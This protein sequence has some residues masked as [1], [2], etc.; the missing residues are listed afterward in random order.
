MENKTLTDMIVREVLKKLNN[1]DCLEKNPKSR[2]AALFCGG[3][4]GSR[5]ALLELKKIVMAGYDVQ[6]FLTPAAE[7]VLGSDLL[8]SE[9]G[10]I[11]MFTETSEKNGPE[12]IQNS[13]IILVPV[14]TI[15]S[16][17]KIA[18]GIADNLVTNLVMQGL[19]WGKTI[20]AARD[21]CDIDDQK[22]AEFGMTQGNQAYR[23]LFRDNLKRLED[24]GIILVEV[25][26]LEAAVRREDKR[27]TCSL[28]AGAKGDQGQNCFNGKVLGTA[29]VLKG[30][31]LSMADV[32]SCIG[33]TLNIEN[34]TLVTP[35]A[36]DLA[37]ER[38][39]EIIRN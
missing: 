27:R 14:L 38:G 20:I 6:T 39:I 1:L 3:K 34:G 18:H 29:A 28:K 23:N 5:E 22:R 9:A 10:N 21:A 37:H 17:A 30:G 35:A 4:I 11:P 2:I 33:P 16:A 25:V 15:N 32:A 26:D 24:Y 12:V 36:Q 7:K 19:F 8:H 31:V 13:D